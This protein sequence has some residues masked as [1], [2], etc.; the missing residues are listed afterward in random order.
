VDLDL[1]LNELGDGEDTQEH[2][3]IHAQIIR[4]GGGKCS[5]CHQF[6]SLTSLSH[7]PT[8]FYNVDIPL[9]S[10]K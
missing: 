7:E 10:S 3:A 1:T 6:S 5:T 9:E 4:K 8:Y 2:Q